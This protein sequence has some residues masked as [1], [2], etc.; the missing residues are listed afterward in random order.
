MPLK[1]AADSISLADTQ[2]VAYDLL[3]PGGVLATFLPVAINTT[4]EKRVIS[5]IGVIKYPSNV[6]LL[7][8]LFHDNFER[9]LKEGLVKVSKWS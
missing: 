1:Y 4:E 8:A 2:Q 9:L 6:K 7:N 5:A 3:A